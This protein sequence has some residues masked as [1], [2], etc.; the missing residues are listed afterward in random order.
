MTSANLSQSAFRG[1]SDTA[2]V[3]TA[4]TWIAA[5]SVNF[6]WPVGTTFRVRFLIQDTTT[7]TPTAS[8]TVKL[9]ANN[10]GGAF[11]DV[12]TASTIVKYSASASSSA[13]QAAIATA[14]LGGTG[15]FAN[16]VYDSAS[17][18]TTATV[19][20]A[21][22]GNTEYE[23]GLTF[24]PTTVKRGDQV[25][26]KV[27]V[28]VGS[29]ITATTSPTITVMGLPA[30]T[31][32]SPFLTMA[33]APAVMPTVWQGTPVR[34]LTLSM[35]TAVHFY[36]AG[37]QAPTEQYSQPPQ[38][39]ATFWTGTPLSSLT[40][41]LANLPATQSYQ[42]R[43][44]F[45]APDLLLQPDW[46]WR[47]PPKNLNLSVAPPFITAQWRNPQVDVTYWNASPVASPAALIRIIA[48]PFS[49]L[50]HPDPQA[51]STQ[52]TGQPIGAATL[53]LLTIGGQP[54][55]KAWRY[56]Y[57]NTTALWQ[58]VPV[59]TAISTI[60]LPPVVT[61]QLRSP[62][63]APNPPEPTVW[64]GTPIISA[65]LIQSL[66][67][68]KPF[69][70]VWRDNIAQETQPWWQGPPL[71]LS[72]VFE[73]VPETLLFAPNPPVEIGWGGS[74]VTAS[75][76]LLTTKIVEPFLKTWRY[77][78]MLDVPLWTGAPIPAAISTIPPPVSTG[79]LR[80]PFYA[81]D[82]LHLTD[83]VWQAPPRNLSLLVPPTVLPFSKLWRA[84]LQLDVPLWFGTPR[85]TAISTLPTSNPFSKLWRYDY[86]IEAP[87]WLGMP[88]RST[89]LADLATK[90]FAKPWRYDLQPEP[91]W[92]WT[93][94]PSAT[95]RLLTEG[96]KPP[97][98]RWRYDLVPD[99]VWTG[100][101]LRS[102]A[103][104]LPKLSPFYKLWRY[105]LV[106]EPFW[107]G[108]PRSAA[109]SSY[110]PQTN[111]FHQQWRYDLVPELFWAWTA[112]GLG[113]LIEMPTVLP[114]GKLWRYDYA[115]EGPPWVWIPPTAWAPY[116]P[117]IPPVPPKPTRNAHGHNIFAT[118]LL[119]TVSST[120]A[121]TQPYPKLP[122]TKVYVN[123]PAA[124]FLRS[125]GFAS[126]LVLLNFVKPDGTLYYVN[127]T[128]FEY[129]AIIL[130][131]DYIVYIS[132]E[133]EF[134]Q[135]GWWLVTMTSGQ[136]TSA[137]FAFYIWP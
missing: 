108:T 43:S 114:F 66:S 13:D 53:K 103:I 79:Q 37:G 34:S 115:S 57:D 52:W 106:P 121:F 137:Q 48:Q 38:A 2:T 127:N 64:T 105:D 24:D 44:P 56:D 125:D 96:G 91:P 85:A 22:S 8:M 9:Q 61:Y 5:Q 59:A 123:Q 101:P 92:T 42:L 134:D 89:I 132:A 47:P 110:T 23:F 65:A 27:V 74:P 118:P 39:D 97:T 78:F 81:P 131:H 82:R 111:P 12:T 102:V 73:G 28:V 54:T 7:G 11:Q 40:L 83:W 3:D 4:P 104:V 31:M 88:V 18:T 94:P 117:I 86:Q 26:L 72:L 16:G 112:P 71:N 87:L 62:F 130:S 41:Q 69:V 19:T 20:I 90:P 33:P 80:S 107:Q 58:G 116:I 49:K 46:T 109:P 30:A 35:L 113:K 126:N 95:L 68:T 63:Y 60:P 17:T 36:G 84:D 129:D 25:I 93:A 70:P 55:N 133:N 67:T 75:L 50:W 136:S 100:T 99:P 122:P 124:L 76:V 1:R 128:T 21:A 51:D 77:D 6:S 14:R 10:N 15:T 29:T 120:E 32:P 98:P 135:P 119:Y 45:Y